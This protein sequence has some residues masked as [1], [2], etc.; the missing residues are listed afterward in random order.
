MKDLSCD[1]LIIGA[2][3]A[4]IEAYIAAKAKGATCIL[5]E[6]GPLGTTAQ[7]TGDIP[8]ASLIE[9]GNCVYQI[10]HSKDYGINL[11]GNF[12]IDTS[13]VMNS[14]RAIRAKATTQILS[15]IYKIPEDLRVIGKASFV[16]DHN[17]CV[18]NEVN[19]KFKT[20]V[21]ATGA[22]PVIPFEFTKLGDVLTTKDIFDLDSL[23]KSLA[24]F[25]AGAVGL[26]IGQALSYLGCDVTI[27]AK[28]KL[29]DITDSN[30]LNVGSTLLSS[31][32]KLAINS[33]ISTIEKED[34]GFGIY[35]LDN[36]KKE[37]YLNVE[38][39][40]VAHSRAANIEGLNLRN[41]GVKLN[42]LGLIDVDLET[43]QT[44]IPHIFAAGDVCTSLM[45]T[46]L[47]KIQGTNAGINAAT[48]PY[49]Y[50]KDNKAKT[51]V[52]FTDPPMAIVGLSLAQMLKRSENGNPFITSEYRANDGI[53]RVK[54]K[55][56]GILRL[57]VDEKSRKI[58]GCEMCIARAESIA[59][60][61][62]LAISKGMTCDDLASFPFHY[63]TAENAIAR[64]CESAIRAL[65]RKDSF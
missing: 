48:Y 2:G 19:I 5:V 6:S 57:Y 47:A 64:A 34:N 46:S 9:A 25:G 12:D 27:F 65:S 22:H 17:I 40:L 60:F 49:V 18:D 41:I 38:K 44:S 14:L 50:V 16:D 54:R 20:C 10:K 56:G 29:W 21:I 23:P 3:S 4:G 26:Q 51:R 55:E 33:K 43:M 7:R 52:I 63:P 59:N 53:F 11:Y 61:L 28:D 45:S 62:A 31:K 42:H 30:V 8:T 35:F 13:D 58:M 1:T 32:I 39:T 36:N 15:F 24:I 37:N